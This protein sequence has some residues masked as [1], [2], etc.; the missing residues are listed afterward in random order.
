MTDRPALSHKR[1]VRA[2]A[3]INEFYNTLQDRLHVALRRFGVVS[4][5]HTTWITALPREENQEITLNS[6]LIYAGID[7]QRSRLE[8]N[9]IITEL[10]EYW[11]FLRE[12]RKSVV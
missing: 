6:K 10:D 1:T 2:F 8:R 3:N 5:K 9:D 4:Q 11:R 7:E 12:D